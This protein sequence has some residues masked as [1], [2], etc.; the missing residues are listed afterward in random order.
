M[1]KKNEE[2]VYQ[3]T[4]PLK[5]IAFIMDGNGRWAKQRLL[6][7]SMGH[8]AGVKNV[9]KIVD[10]CFDDFNIFAC[11][12]FVFST[13]NWNRPE[14]EISY[15]FNL[16]KV[17]FEDNIDEFKEK[18]V[19][20][21]VSGDLTDSRIPEDVLST[22][23]KAVEETK[24]GKNHVFNV[25]FN[26]GGRREIVYAAKRIAEDYKNNKIDLDSIDE[27][28]FSKNLYNSSL[29]DV[30][31]LIRTSGEERISNC[32]LYELAYSEL[33][34]TESYWP[35]FTKEDLIKCLKEYESRNRR[36]GGLKNE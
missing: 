34:F 32:I 6:P 36:F 31:L 27:K 26:Y 28:Y 1:S 17:F 9:K 10:S 3:L 16:L 19:Q 4:K 11:S 29:V 23:N 7:R 13:E 35:S 24:D 30:D 21:I 5:H 18:G 22:I 15:L 14:H 25:L 12:L 2:E 20:V 8:K 33:I